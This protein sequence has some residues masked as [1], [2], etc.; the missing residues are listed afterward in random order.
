MA[1]GD[2]S[3]SVDAVYLQRRLA[4]VG[5][6]MTGV[7][8]LILLAQLGL[9][10]LRVLRQWNY[11]IAAVFG[12]SWATLWLACKYVPMTRQTLRRVEAVCVLTGACALAVVARLAAVEA[13]HDYHGPAAAHP[14]AFEVHV[15]GAFRASSM[16]VAL[17]LALAMAARAA[18]VPTSP[19]Y[20]GWL[21]AGVGVPLIVVWLVDVQ[22]FVVTAEHA[23]TPELM[24]P[25]L[26]A[27]WWTITTGICYVISRVVHGL[28]VE[29]L[30]ARKMGQ[31]TLVERIGQGGMGEVYRARHNR[32]RRPTALKLLLAER[33]GEQA[34]ARF[35]AEVQLTAE[36]TH[37]NTIT[38]FD[39]GR[40]DEGVFYYAME[41]LDGATLA[42]VVE[43]AGAQTPARVIRILERVAGALEE[44]HQAGLIHRDIKPSNIMLTRQ[45]LDMDAPKVLDFGLV[46]PVN[47]SDGDLTRDGDLVGTPLYMAPETIRSAEDAS[48]RS[49]IY[50]LGAVGYFLLTGEHVFSG[51]SI[52]EICAHH[53]HTE[54]EPMTERL[55]KPVAEDLA[56]LV[57]SCLAKSPDGRPT[58]ARALISQL[59]RCA[60]HDSWSTNDA[61]AWW[62]RHRLALRDLHASDDEPLSH[63]LTIASA[64]PRPDK[65]SMA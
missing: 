3:T 12:L 32:L 4:V 5:A 6:L 23:G 39:Y 9:N 18:L 57:M 25:I 49:D 61:N 36:L 26:V 60:D 40:T 20:T 48:A 59:A 7:T 27:V 65:L 11:W 2:H 14:L 16:S 34:M 21:T 45:G 24:V 35:E 15:A 56:G 63:T 51:K 52:V 17:A 50:A 62:N 58:D 54:P 33:S 44:A 22:L 13:F 19:R 29:V 28:R 10:G 42:D 53:L 55:G 64:G 1:S 46:R 30:A 8:V 43:V 47:R 38:I 41:L 31:Y 37:P